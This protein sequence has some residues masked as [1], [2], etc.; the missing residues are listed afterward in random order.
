[1]QSCPLLEQYIIF[2][3]QNKKHEH[4]EVL[5]HLEMYKKVVLTFTLMQSCAGV[6]RDLT[7]DGT[8]FPSFLSFRT[9]FFCYT[10]PELH[11][12]DSFFCDRTVI[13]LWYALRE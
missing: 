2:F 3:P 10:F 9:V 8:A 1:M 4:V 6:I 13:T 11:P 7:E 5:S 12:K